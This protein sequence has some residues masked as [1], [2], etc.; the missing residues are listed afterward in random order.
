MNRI[1]FASLLTCFTPACAATETVTQPQAAQQAPF[2]YGTWY[3][4]V[5]AALA[6]RDAYAHS[7]KTGVHDCSLEGD[8]RRAQHMAQLNSNVQL[9]LKKAKD[10]G[11]SLGEFESIYSPFYPV[12]EE[13]TSTTGCSCPHHN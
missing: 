9:L 7:L 1:I 4:Q 13:P 6:A 11:Q 5:K 10:A 2:D 12:T 8:R 3:A